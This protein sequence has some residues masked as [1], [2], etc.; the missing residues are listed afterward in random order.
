MENGGLPSRH[1][2]AVRL[3]VYL[4]SSISYLLAVSGCDLFAPRAPEAPVVES[5]TYLLPSEPQD[6]VANLQA[7]VAELNTQNYRRIFAD[8]FTFV[9]TAPSLAQNPSIWAGWGSMQE[10]E[11]FRQLRE[12]AASRTGHELRLDASAQTGTFVGDD[13]Y[14]L[15]APYV[16]TVNHGRPSLPVTFQGRLV[17][18]LRRSDDGLWYLQQ[19]TDEPVGGEQSWSDLKAAVVSG[20]L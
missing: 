2:H 12:A 6:V 4:L 1:V 17:W 19:W 13:R 18:V 5:G 7:A 15:Q 10:E 16:L 14:E 11:Y 8:D 9:P 3:G 20:Q